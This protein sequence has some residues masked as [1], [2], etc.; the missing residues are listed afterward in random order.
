MKNHDVQPSSAA[1]S[2]IHYLANDAAVRGLA[3]AYVSGAAMLNGA[4]TGY[5]RVLLAHSQI[6]LGLTE[7]R[8][9]SAKHITV[10]SAAD[11]TA[12]RTALDATA[13]R[14]YKLVLDEVGNGLKGRGAAIERHSRTAFARS[15]AS[16]LRACVSV[17]ID[18]RNIGV[19]DAAK[20][21]LAKLASARRPHRAASPGR[22]LASV[23]RNITT[24]LDAL[25][26]AQARVVA[27]AM[28][29]EIAAWL[30]KHGKTTR[31]AAKAL[32]TSQ[33]W[34]TKT[35]VFMPVHLPAPSAQQ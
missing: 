20:G 29:D 1:L 30:V 26:E 34:A 15:A 17:G 6:A 9:T 27:Q 13:D 3:R 14:L 5:L 24:T 31:K 35:G 33:P 12:Q 10:L 18:L 28:A 16:T 19:A 8:I 22:K 11:K 7:P 32:A 4:R 25:P 2:A 23:R 21:A